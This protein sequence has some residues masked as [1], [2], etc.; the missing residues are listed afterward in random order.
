MRMRK[1]AAK[2]A[3]RAAKRAHSL[4][5]QGSI[6]YRTY[7]LRGRALAR[8]LGEYAALAC[9]ISFLFYQSFWP[10][11]GAWPFAWRYS[12]RRADRLRRQRQGELRRQFLTGMQMVS[13]AQRAGYAAENAFREAL[14][15][16]IETYGQEAWIVLEF[17]QI[18][19]QV[20]LNVP[21]EKLLIDLG[22]RSGVDDIESF[23]EV[24]SAA[25]RSGGDLLAILA[26]TIT[27]IEQKEETMRQIE[28]LLSGRRM[29]WKIMSVAP[30]AIL[31]Y[32]RLTSPDF[33]LPMY[34]NP[35]GILTMTGCLA[36]Y[37]VAYLWGEKILEI[38]G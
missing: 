29:E 5:Q 3:H 23:A 22:E 11:L 32:I 8:C 25:R 19:A 28:T 38:E 27:G 7:K 16:L 14:G 35:A 12:K 26:N 4:G 13:T 37:G 36:V 2:R 21:L 6:D 30:M 17:R 18:A 15:G 33:L 9:G 24:F 31:A 34:A 1:I 20:H 10:L